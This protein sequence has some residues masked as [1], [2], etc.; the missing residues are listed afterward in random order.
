MDARYDLAVWRVAMP[1][2]FLAYGRAELSSDP[3]THRTHL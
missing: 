3:C 2:Q 1:D